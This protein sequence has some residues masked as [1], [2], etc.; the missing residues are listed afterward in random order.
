MSF[1]ASADLHQQ[2][3]A[4]KHSSPFHSAPRLARSRQCRGH[5]ATSASKQSPQLTQ[6]NQLAQDT[7]SLLLPTTL[8]LAMSLL[9]PAGALADATMSTPPS[10]ASTSSATQAASR[11]VVD[12][13]GGENTVLNEA[14]EQTNRDNDQS[15]Q[16]EKQQPT[17]ASK[18]R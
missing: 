13:I 3:T 18:A 4:C 7:R 10:T 16:G 14:N 5:P 15:K 2:L 12:I 9:Q 1:N 6:L 11:T 17:D 8:A